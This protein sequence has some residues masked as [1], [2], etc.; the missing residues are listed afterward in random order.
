MYNYVY[1]YINICIYI[2]ICR[3]HSD[4]LPWSTK[5]FCFFALTHSV[6]SKNKGYIL[7]RWR[8]DGNTLTCWQSFRSQPQPCQLLKNCKG[9]GAL[10]PSC[11]LW[12]GEVML[13]VRDD[14]LELTGVAMHLEY[15]RTYGVSETRYSIPPKPVV[16]LSISTHSYPYPYNAYTQSLFSWNSWLL[17]TP[18]ILLG[19]FSLLICRGWT[20]LSLFRICR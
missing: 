9:R 6:S 12:N 10:Y 15:F 4:F 13:L 5:S 20:E 8:L 1:T 18:Q 19:D 14:R 16:P 3:Y 17:P 2:Y 7:Q 11:H